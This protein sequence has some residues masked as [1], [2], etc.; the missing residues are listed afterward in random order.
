M[1]PIP[2]DCDEI[3][4]ENCDNVDAYDDFIH[5]DGEPLNAKAVTTADIDRLKGC[6]GESV[7]ISGLH[8]DPLDYFIRCYA[9]RFR[10]FFLYKCGYIPDLS[11][12]GTLTKMEGI[13]IY[14][15]RT[16][17]RLWDLSGNMGLRKL[18]LHGF[19]RLH[20]LDGLEKAPAL[21]TF[22]IGSWENCSTVIS[23]VPDLSHSRLERVRILARITPEEL[24]SFL[25]APAL[26]C[27]DFRPQQFKVEFLAWINANFPNLD[28]YSLHPYILHDDDYVTICGKGHRVYPCR[29]DADAQQAMRQAIKKFGKLKR[30]LRGV[31]FDEAAHLFR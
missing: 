27:L 19:S 9:D 24:Y 25:R 18:F 30:Q 2:L 17:D 1:L 23:H 14:L 3:N 28:G 8:A 29:D 5:A 12:L 4:L 26:R 20:D 16:V 11:P 15:N 10:F 6:R 21:T 13:S 22:C 31:P 7:V